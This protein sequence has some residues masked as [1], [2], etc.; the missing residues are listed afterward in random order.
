M[1]NEVIGM[2]STVVVVVVWLVRMEGRVN[3]QEQR[4]TDHIQA[5][6]KEHE[7]HKKRHEELRDDILYIRDRIDRAINGNGHA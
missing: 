5:N 1:V 4:H 6:S 2:V 7:Q 3:T